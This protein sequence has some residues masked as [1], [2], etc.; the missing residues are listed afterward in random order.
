[1][2]LI[3]KTFYTASLTG[4]G[5]VGYLASTTQVVSP[6]PRDDTLW[7]SNVYAKYNRYKNPSTQDIVSRRIPIEKIKPELLKNEADLTVEFCRGVWSGLGQWASGVCVVDMHDADAITGYRFQ[8]AYLARKYQGPATAAQLW[9]VDQLATSSYNRGDVLTDHFEVVDKSPNEITVRC[10]DTPRNSGPRDSDGLFIIGARIDRERREAVLTLK[11]C[12]FISSRKVEGIA[13]PMPI[14]ME[15]LHQ[16][17][18]RLWLATGSWK[19][20][21]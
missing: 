9:T 4:A 20:M 15:Q 7:N 13:G 21:R 2:G 17:Y 10:G 12:L 16:W 11:S 1:M 6:L 5:L 14:W 19:V 8:R 3:K 18:A